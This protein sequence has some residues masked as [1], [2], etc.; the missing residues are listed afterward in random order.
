ML[1][2]NK[3]MLL[4]IGVMLFAAGMASGEANCRYFWVVRDGLSS[5]E[6]VD[7]L[8]SRA[9]AAGA[10]GIMVQVVG[11][12][13]AYYISDLLPPADF[14]GFE[15]P[16][17]YVI[18]KAGPMG[19]EVHA[20]VNAYLV[21]S[22]PW[23]PESRD[24]I[25]HTHPEWFTAHSNGRSSTSYTQD[26]AESV[27]LVGAT[28]SPAFHGVRGYITDIA[29]ELAEN[30]NIKGIHLDYIRYPNSSFGYSQGELE[31][32]QLATGSSP[33]EDPEQWGIWRQQQVTETVAAVRASLRS[34]DPGVLLSCAVMANPYSAA[35][36]FSCD[37]QNWLNLGLVDFVCPMAY[38]SDPERAFELAA[39][40]TSVYP[41]KVVYGIGVWNQTVSN[42]LAGAQKA[43]SFGAGG[44]CVFSLNSLPDGGEQTL[45]RSWGT[46]LSPEHGVSP[47]YFNRVRVP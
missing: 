7:E 9:Q 11:R 35:S 42:A 1:H 10:N 43:L 2:L 47:A 13:E 20:W 30:Y 31:L 18:Q 40:T 32:F 45:R 39:V 22:A 23:E 44:I 36:E 28:L 26:Q 29:V 33:E 38:T 15:D 4:Y 5:P 3:F 21:W 17:K 41:E 16:L 34:A 46:G 27:G 8:L 12:G 6:Q 24:H 14:S 19:M 37:W 25:Y